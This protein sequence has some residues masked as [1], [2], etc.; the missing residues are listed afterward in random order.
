MEWKI[1]NKIYGIKNETNRK[2]TLT[3]N[4]VR[5]PNRAFSSLC[6]LENSIKPLIFYHL[7][8]KNKEVN[9]LLPQIPNIRAEGGLDTHLIYACLHLYMSALKGMLWKKMQRWQCFDS[10][11][12]KVMGLKSKLALKK[13]I[14]H[15]LYGQIFHLLMGKFDLRLTFCLWPLWKPGQSVMSTWSQAVTGSG[16]ADKETKLPE[17]S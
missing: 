17:V 4:F 10:Q 6:D 15:L 1:V 5:W 12:V 7:H 2:I 16:E 3:V 14:F 9:I 13:K 11:K 8:M